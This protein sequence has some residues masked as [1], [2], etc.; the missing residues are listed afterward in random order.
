M[1]LNTHLRT[2]L[3]GPKAF[4]L[5]VRDADWRPYAVKL[6]GGRPL[7]AST[8]RIFVGEQFSERTLACLLDNGHMALNV[9][10]ATTLE[11]YQFKGMYLAHSDADEEDKERIKA[12]FKQFDELLQ[13]WGLPAG[14][15]YA[16]PHD[17]LIAI[18]F[19]VNQ[20]FEQTPKKGTG[21]HVKTV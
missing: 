4:N 14:S 8:I 2:F 21:N 7:D 1:I 18:D 17:P 9:V 16:L 5:G 13:K 6:A 19:E 10:D 3:E 20:V 11:C 12:N 15:V